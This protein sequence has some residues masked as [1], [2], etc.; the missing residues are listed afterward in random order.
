MSTPYRSTQATGKA[1]K[2]AQTSLPSSPRKIRYV[3]ESIAKK[4]GLSVDS[5]PSSSTCNYGALSED[6]KLVVHVFYS[7]NDTT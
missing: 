2:R 5:S 4:V 1:M 7:S 6:A 3:V